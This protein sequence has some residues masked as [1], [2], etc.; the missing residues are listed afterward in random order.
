[1]QD[2]TSN[3]QIPM[4]RSTGTPAR[5][6]ITLTICPVTEM[7]AVANCPDKQQKS[8]R[9]GSEPKEYCPFHR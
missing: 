5:G 8:F 9:E 4:Q 2:N 1:M 3:G 7:R 6:F